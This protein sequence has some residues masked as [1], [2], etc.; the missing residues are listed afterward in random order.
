MESDKILERLR[1]IEA[2][3][4]KL[5]DA[6]KNDVVL[7]EKLNTLN[8]FADL[9]TQQLKTKVQAPEPG[10]A[11]PALNSGF[12]GKQVSPSISYLGSMK[13]NPGLEHVQ[14]GSGE[15]FS[16]GSKNGSPFSS[17]GADAPAIPGSKLRTLVALERLGPNASATDVMKATQRSRSV[18]SNYLNQLWKEGLLVK[19]QTPDGSILFSLNAL[20]HSALQQNARITTL[21][22]QPVV[23]SPLRIEK[24]PGYLPP[25]DGV[26]FED[27]MRPSFEV[28]PSDA[29]S[30]L[31]C[32]DISVTP[33]I[34]RGEGQESTRCYLGIALLDSEYN[35]MVNLEECIGKPVPHAS[36]LDEVDVGFT[37]FEG[38][39]T[40]LKLSGLNLHS[41]PENVLDL[42][43]LKY[44]DLSNNNIKQLPDAIGSLKNL[45]FLVINN[46]K[47]RGLP[48]TIG[49]LK[50]LISLDVYRNDI[51]AIP[52]DVGNLESLVRFDAHDNKIVHLPASLLNLKKLKYLFLNEN[53]LQNVDGSLN[54][55]L[56][57]FKKQSCAK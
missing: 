14:L 50:S 28:R 24:M 51:S 54:E 9:A 37:S 12:H 35:V 46:N 13:V 22:D 4:L 30:I 56:E 23:S 38:N 57:Q 20:G 15:A 44:L 3:L 8:I 11:T 39:V 55:W 45:E 43:E 47:V 21:K 16:P 5:E 41:F 36:S 7:R 29:G 34:L 49:Q 48:D 53:Q 52:K 17:I 6:A 31:A 40:G 27:A 19:R 18:E 2:R 1:D 25:R 26:A 10:T 33:L 32:A 42:K